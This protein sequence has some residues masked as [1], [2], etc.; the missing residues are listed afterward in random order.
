MQDAIV[1]V[2]AAGSARGHG[3][4]TAPVFLAAIS[5]ILGAILFL[6][7]GYAVG[8]LGLAGALL[9]VLLGHMVTIPTALA[10]AEIATN[11][12][13]EGGGE[14]YIVSRSFGT[15]IGSVVGISLYA[16]QAVSVAFYM[17]AFAEAFRPLAPLFERLTGLLFDPRMVS[18]PGAL[19]LVVLILV[20]G[21]AIGVG[22]LYVVVTLLAAALLLFFMGAPLPGFDPEA[23][24]LTAHVASADPFITVFAIVF[25]AFTG[26]TAGVGLSGD[27]AD[28]RRSIPR[29]TLGATL[30]GC[31]VYIAV[32]VKLAYSAPLEALAGRPLVM[33]EVALWGPIVPIGL[34]CATL[35]S[36]IGSVLVAPRTLQALGRDAALPG[37]PLSR[38]LG[39]GHGE[40]NEPRNATLVTAVVALTVVWLGSVDLVARL[41]SMFFMITYGSICAIS[42]LEHFAA[43]PSYRPSFRSRWYVSLFGALTCLLVMFQMD[44]FFALLALFTMGLLYWSLSTR[45]RREGKGSDLGA[46]F[47]GAMTQLARDLHVRLQRR[48]ELRRRGEWRPSII[49]VSSHTFERAAPIELLSWLCLRQGFGTYLHHVQ[50]TLNAETFQ[51]SQRARHR[52]LEQVSSRASGLY[53][54][55]VVSPSMTSA[56]AQAL[57]VPGISGLP[58]NAALF[59]IS[60]HDTSTSAEEVARLATFAAHA[61]MAVL[62]LRH[63]DAHFGDHNAIHVWLT[64]DDAKNAD[65]MILLAYIILGHP[66]WT[67]AELRVFAAL[68]SEQVADE[69]EEFGKRM[70]EGRIPVASKNIRFLAADDSAA[71]RASVSERS[72]DADL[73]ILGFSLSDLAERGAELF[74]DHPELTDVLFVC[75]PRRISIT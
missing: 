61:E 47:E 64:W 12:R 60:V 48:R 6:R 46:I 18:L 53:V 62:M 43:R 13:V 36:A 51:E 63:G 74:S 35:S 25:P 52:L 41:I 21:A 33:A 37:R 55:T 16:S 65:L 19:V 20:R 4:G 17:I 72:R 70:A 22:A 45:S 2:P 29:G 54:D 28:P 73:V 11:R 50:G 3:F 71:F 59:D 23:V 68:P 15:T 1:K 10:L 27:L 8:H 32:V 24:A 66:D 39:R 58:N 57:Q 40:V 9:V 49:C 30:V 69:R 75:A 14:Y 67:H 34:A 44:P 42:F 26:M 5:T 38:W 56:V 31:A 7:F